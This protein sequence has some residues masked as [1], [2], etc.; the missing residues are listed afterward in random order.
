M[1]CFTISP[2]RKRGFCAAAAILA[3]VAWQTAIAGPVYELVPRSQITFQPL[4]PL[5]G[6]A[7]PKAGTLWGDIRE[8]TASGALIE[9]AEGFSSPPHIHNITYRGVVI[10][11][12]V[13][14]DDPNAEDLWMGTGS[15]WIQPAGEV[16]ITAARPGASATAFLEIFHGPY[17][18]QPGEQAFDN[19]ERPVNIDYANLVWLEASD[20]SWLT[21]ESKRGST[22]RPGTAFLWG[23]TSPGR[24]NG[25]LLRLPPGVHGEL[26]GNDAWLRAVVIE[27]L[28]TYRVARQPNFVSL[29]PGSYFGSSQHGVHGLSCESSQDC[30]VYVRTEGPYRFTELQAARPGN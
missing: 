2:W 16:H 30:L 13:H 29:E 28:V 20:T 25:T 23:D 22:E 14:N 15:F 11:G 9:F 17:L 24:A 6:D 1:N 18:V 3:L 21:Q 5:R 8:D 26:A 7:S 27:G 10:S 19:G 4:N 12:A